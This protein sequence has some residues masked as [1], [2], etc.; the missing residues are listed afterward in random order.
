MGLSDSVG[1]KIR[2]SWIF[3]VFSK[4]DAASGYSRKSGIHSIDGFA[5]LT[6]DKVVQK[7]SKQNSI[8]V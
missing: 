6:M 8:P 5:G 2:P 4:K 7:Q 1:L 3:S